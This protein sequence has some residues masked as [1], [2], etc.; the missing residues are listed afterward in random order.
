[1]RKEKQC[2][3]TMVGHMRP[4]MEDADE[5]DDGFHGLCNAT[6][7]RGGHQIPRSCKHDLADNVGRQVSA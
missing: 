2:S 1:M 3:Y 5:A 6:V 7:G 4:K